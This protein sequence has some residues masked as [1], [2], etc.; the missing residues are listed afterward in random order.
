V[1]SGGLAEKR[2]IQYEGHSYALQGR[3]GWVQLD[4]KAPV[5]FVAPGGALTLDGKPI[6]LTPTTGEEE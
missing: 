2:T 5:G 3:M 1:L 4:G 6:P